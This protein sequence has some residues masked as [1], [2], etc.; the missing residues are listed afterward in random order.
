MKPFLMI[1]ISLLCL[2]SA[3]A[4]FALQAD[5]V[6]LI[7]NRNNASS[8]E[9]AEYYRNRRQIP[10]ANLLTVNMTDQEDCSREE[11]QQKLIEPVRKYLARRKGTPIRCLLLFYG[12]PLRVAAPELSPQQWQE[13]EDLKY[14]KKQLDWQLEHRQLT[15]EQKQQHQQKSKQLG[16]QIDK[17]RRT[18]QRAAIDSEIALVLNDSYPLER[19]QPNPFFVGFSKQ[20]NKLLFDKDQVLFVSRLDGPTPEIVRRVIDDSLYA[21]KEG[22][23][24][25]AYFDARWKMPEKKHLEGYALYDA[26]I[27]KAAELTGKLS[28]LPV[29]FDQD[30]RL[31]QPGEAPRAA[32]YCGWYSLGK[33]VDAFDWQ[34]GAVGYHIASSEATTLKKEGSQVW[35]KR[36]LEDGIAATV[37]PVAEPYVQ[38]FPLPEL[39]FG[40]LLDGYYTLAESYFLSTPY[41]S[42][43]M[44]LIGDPLYRPFRNI[45][46]GK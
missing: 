7:V 40:F 33:Y 5:E 27:H 24:G 41:L 6:L 45:I 12:I 8:I 19:W 36:M 23:K 20:R 37:G 32:L 2:V 43:Q 21:E 22:L 42:W 35:C 44:I 4:C 9:L 18:D 38:G 25:Q 28:S 11:Y 13:L 30:E 14:T 10:Q 1:L 17:L 26:S 31:F 34:R 16:T 39:F 3:K 46:T 15:E 29:H